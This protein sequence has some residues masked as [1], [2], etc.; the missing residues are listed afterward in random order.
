MEFFQHS[1]VQDKNGKKLQVFSVCTSAHFSS[2]FE[3]NLLN[4]YSSRNVSN[5]SHEEE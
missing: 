4:A 2:Y 5:K 3:C 1:P